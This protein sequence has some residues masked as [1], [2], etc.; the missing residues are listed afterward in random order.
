MFISVQSANNITKEI[1]GV[2]LMSESG[3]TVK[4]LRE[5]DAGIKM[6]ISSINE[7]LDNVHDDE[8]KSKL[9]DCRNQHEKLA[10]EIEDL[11]EAHRDEGKSPN[12][13]I[14]GMSWIKTNVKLAADNSD[15][16]IADL[17]TD[18]ANMGVKSLSRYI[19]QYRSA[20]DKSRDISNRLVDIEARLSTDMRRYL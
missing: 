20:D 1:K 4:L 7:V 13:M 14:K 16:T 11:L 15:K 6:G 5:C 3:D 12:P 8:F 19:N 18:G 17:M 10:D 2:E 9:I